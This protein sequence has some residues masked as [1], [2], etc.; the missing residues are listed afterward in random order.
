MWLVPETYGEY[1]K[2]NMQ[3]I[4]DKPNPGHYKKYKETLEEYKLFAN[5]LIQRMEA[6]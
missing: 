5:D 4:V 1:E 2:K 6:L 3:T